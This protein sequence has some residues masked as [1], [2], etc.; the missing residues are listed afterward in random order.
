MRYPNARA[1]T[2]RP[3]SRL[4]SALGS[5]SVLWLLFWLLAIVQPAASAETPDFDL[6]VEIVDAP[7][8]L[9]GAAGAAVD[10]DARVLLATS[11]LP[12]GEEG[13]QGWSI[14]VAQ[15]GAAV[16]REATT[17]GT[18]AAPV[19]DGG[20]FSGGFAQTQLT[21]GSGND[22]V[23]SAVVLSFSDGT[24]LP[25]SGEVALL[26]LD[27]EVT[28]PSGGCDDVALLLEDG[29]QGTGQPVDNKITWKGDT[30]RDDGGDF[31]ADGDPVQNVRIRVCPVGGTGFQRGNCDGTGSINVAD[32]IFALNR[33]FLGGSTPACMDACDTDDNGTFNITD[34][35]YALNYL[36]LGGGQPPAPFPACGDDP[37][38]DELDCAVP[39][40]TCE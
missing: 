29:L 20:Y 19:A 18:A 3:A 11:G 33:L 32:A 1:G 21:A 40:P 17:A 6:R 7:A 2:V 28:I 27:V 16:I 10:L 24:T 26:A 8:V 31:D 15:G 34:A 9:T 35:V 23:V 4:S 5:G 22:G 36:F 38:D 30:Y 12:D 25:P 13:A 37:T 39:H 14:S